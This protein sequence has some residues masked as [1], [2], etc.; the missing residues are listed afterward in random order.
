[1]MSCSAL[2]KSATAGSRNDRSR[3]PDLASACARDGRMIRLERSS[4]PAACRRKPHAIVPGYPS[5]QASLSA[6][7]TT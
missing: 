3:H 5:A 1:M 7:A 4:G 2:G 6:W